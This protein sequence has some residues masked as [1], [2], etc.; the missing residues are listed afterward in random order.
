MSVA[1]CFITGAGTDVGKTFVAAGV[2]RALRRAGRPCDALK[3]VVSGF[4]DASPEGSDPLVL[5]RAL[6]RPA[7]GAALA[8]ISPWRFRAPL[9]PDMAAAAAARAIDFGKLVEACQAA[10]RDAE[11]VLL[12]EGAGGV[13]VPLTARET[14][15]DLMQALGLPLIFVCGSYLGAI[16]HALTALE[17]LRGRGLETRAIVVNE[18]C[19]ATVDLDATCATLARFVGAPLLA[20]PREKPS[21]AT[22]DRLAAMF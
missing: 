2:L 13:M 3:P 1:A 6:G 12:I 15:L 11:G 14:T 8:R 21:D 5:L 9:S 20:L 4:D 10:A 22:F 17:A 18:T 7:S 16:S 19:S